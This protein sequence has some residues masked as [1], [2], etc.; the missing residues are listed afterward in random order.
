MLLVNR[1]EPNI[2]THMHVDKIFALSEFELSVVLL[3]VAM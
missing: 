3:E 2:D 1:K